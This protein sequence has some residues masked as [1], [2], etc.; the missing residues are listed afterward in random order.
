M[1]LD[2]ASLDQAVA[3]GRK[4]IA[5]DAVMLTKLT[6]LAGEFAVNL[7]I[8]ILIFIATLFAAKGA[9]GAARR[10]LSRV[11]GFRHDPTVLSFAVQVVRVVVIIV[12]MIAMAW[13]KSR[14]PKSD[15][16]II[17]GPAI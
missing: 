15:E 1:P 9:S 17:P 8:A 3:A 16:P 6:E 7:T 14:Q 13:W 5:V 11:R 10:A 4:A 12:G 2:A